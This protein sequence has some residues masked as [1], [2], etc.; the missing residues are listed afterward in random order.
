MLLPFNVS[1]PVI[2]FGAFEWVVVVVSVLRRVIK[3]N[4]T[5]E[6]NSTPYNNSGHE[7]TDK[8]VLTTDWSKFVIWSKFESVIK[9]TGLITFLVRTV[10]IARLQSIYSGQQQ[11][12][13]KRL[14]DNWEMNVCARSVK[15]KTGE[16]S[17]LYLKVQFPTWTTVCSRWKSVLFKLWPNCVGH[18]SPYYEL[19]QEQAEMI[20]MNSTLTLARRHVGAFRAFQL[21][22]SGNAPPLLKQNWSR[23]VLVVVQRG[24]NSSWPQNQK[25]CEESDHFPYVKLSSPKRRASEC[26]TT[27]ERTH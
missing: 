26:R 9:V 21:Q 27:T 1:F 5:R 13:D 24:G 6:L 11:S 3:S 2:R 17:N 19:T 22:N 7:Y 10:K 12:N 8:F 20:V 15:P 25:H 4:R 14:K 16:S 18:L 23:E